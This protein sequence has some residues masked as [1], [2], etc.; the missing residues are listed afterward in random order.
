MIVMFSIHCDASLL[1]KILIK[2]AHF[3]RELYC[4]YIQHIYITINDNG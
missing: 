1:L 2:C 4:R 3:D